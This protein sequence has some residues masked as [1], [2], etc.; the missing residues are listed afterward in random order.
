MSGGPKPPRRKT[1]SPIVW[2]KD[3][4]SRQR[5]TS[6]MELLSKKLY[7]SLSLDAGA[8]KENGQL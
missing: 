6:V 8:E 1:I 5:L 3:V 2:G 7:Q 4:P